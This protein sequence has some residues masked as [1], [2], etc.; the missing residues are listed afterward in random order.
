MRAEHAGTNVLGRV[1][2]WNE[3]AVPEGRQANEMSA[4]TLVN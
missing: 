1:N 3:N 4:F 2:A